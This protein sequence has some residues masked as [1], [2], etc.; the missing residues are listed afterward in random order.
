MR[1]TDDQIIQLIAEGSHLAFKEL[2]ERFKD[3]V[4]NTSLSYCQS[5]QDAEEI[6]QEVFTKIFT[7]AHQFKASSSVSTWIYRITINTS[8]NHLKRNQI[9]PF[10]SF[11][12]K[13]DKTIDFIHPGVLLER[14]EESKLLFSLID[15]LPESQKTAFILSYIEHLPRKEVADIMNTSL[16]SVESLLQR[17]KKKLRDKLKNMYPNRRKS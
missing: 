17:A 6:T 8:I 5:P 1:K 3:K 2:Y 14:Q 4:Y 7:K 12:D 16:K 15:T 13:A 9:K 11:Y 10:I